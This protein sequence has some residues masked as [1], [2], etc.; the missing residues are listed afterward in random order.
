MIEP[1]NKY[2]NFSEIVGI[3]CVS[4]I[5]HLTVRPLELNPLEVFIYFA[6]DE[7]SDRAYHG[8]TYV[9]RLISVADCFGVR[10]SHRS[11]WLTF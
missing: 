2:F 11:S 6:L 10:E 3:G 9:S 5:Q 7:L 8:A 1:Q 4:R